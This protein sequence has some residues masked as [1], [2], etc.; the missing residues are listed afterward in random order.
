MDHGE[1]WFQLRKN[2]FTKRSVMQTT[3]SYHEKDRW[4]LGEVREKAYFERKS[5]SAVI[6]AILE[7]YFLKGKRIGEILLTTDCLSEEELKQGKEI[8][9]RENGRRCLGEILLEQGFV[10]ERDLKKALAIQNRSS[11][12]QG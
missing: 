8:Q 3:F 5:K 2:N 10:K 11:L 12:D 9:K 4:I 6:V 1:S 7:E